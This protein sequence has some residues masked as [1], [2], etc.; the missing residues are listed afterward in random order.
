VTPFRFGR[1]SVTI[2][3]RS[4]LA[5]VTF[6][7]GSFALAPP[8]AGSTWEIDSAHTNAQFAVRHLLVSKVRGHLGRVTGTVHIDESDLT[9]STAVA[10]VDVTGIDTGNEDRDEHLR[11]ADY[12]DTAKYPTLTFRSK[13]VERKGEDGFAV[14]GE[15]T[16]HGV[17]REVVIEVEGATKPIQ[18]PWGKARLGGVIRTT[19]SREEFAIGGQKVMD[20]GGLVMGDDVDVT[21]DIELTK[22]DD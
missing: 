10:T 13:A 5:L 3:L 18:D 9:K 15:L 4:I 12:L 20:G 22:T 17:T 11:T 1:P 7:T 16:L 6:V 19:L 21:I 8:V 2:S 14:T